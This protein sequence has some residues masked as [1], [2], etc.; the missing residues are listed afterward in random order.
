MA[1]KTETTPKGLDIGENSAAKDF[2]QIC[3]YGANCY[4]KNPM[5]HQ[6]FRHPTKETPTPTNKR[7]EDDS[8]KE[9]I[10]ADTNI[11]TSDTRHT[12]KTQELNVHPPL[13]KK[14]KS[15]DE[16]DENNSESETN[17]SILNEKKVPLLY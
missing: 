14:I 2:R 7:P 16:V 3:K 13:A 17:K 15:S 12:E 6:K 5:H 11:T 9:N 1:G 8:Q 4:Q 10:N